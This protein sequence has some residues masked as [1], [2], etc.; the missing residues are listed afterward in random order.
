MTTPILS[1]DGKWQWVGDQWVEVPPPKRSQ[2]RRQLGW[3][4][5]ILVLVAVVGVIVEGQSLNNRDS[6]N[7]CDIVKC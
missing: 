5:L 6:S 3:V 2:T 1:P 4:L 7:Y